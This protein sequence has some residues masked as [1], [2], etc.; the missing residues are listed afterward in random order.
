MRLFATVSHG[1][2]HG[3]LTWRLWR[4][5]VVVEKAMALFHYKTTTSPMKIS[6]SPYPNSEWCLP[7]VSQ[8]NG[9]ARYVF[10]AGS[11]ANG[12]TAG[13]IFDEIRK[14]GSIQELSF[15]SIGTP[16]P[17]GW[18]PM[19]KWLV[20]VVFCYEYEAKRFEENCANVRGQGP[21]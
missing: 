16:A 9:P 11:V 10:S 2:A 19:K 20:R 15:K 1:V 21:V 5:D 6:L 12:I 3:E 4:A 17:K 14:W 13:K 18:F 7:L 8:S